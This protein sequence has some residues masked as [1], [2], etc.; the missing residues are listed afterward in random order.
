V[1]NG[2]LSI[3]RAFCFPDGLKK[4]KKALHRESYIHRVLYTRET[5]QN[6]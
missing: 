3:P 4:K 1:G 6:K 5:E 2:L